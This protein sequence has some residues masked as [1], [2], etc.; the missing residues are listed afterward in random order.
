MPDPDTGGSFHRFLKRGVVLALQKVL[1]GGAPLLAVLLAGVAG[2]ATQVAGISYKLSLGLILTT[3]S[4]LGVS[5]ILLRDLA[6]ASDGRQLP[7]EGVVAL[8]GLLAGFLWVLVLSGPWRAHPLLVDPPALLVVIAIWSVLGVH[9]YSMQAVGQG[10]GRY[11]MLGRTYVASLC[12]LSGFWM[13]AVV[14]GRQADLLIGCGLLAARALEVAVYAVRIQQWKQPRA[15][16][17]ATLRLC[18]SGA[19]VLGQQLSGMAHSRITVL[20]LAGLL[21]RDEFARFSI[22]RSVYSGL[23]LVPAALA[24]GSFPRFVQELRSSPG[25]SALAS[26]GSQTARLIFV[27]STVALAVV[28]ALALVPADWLPLGNV[29]MKALFI[30]MVLA[31]VVTVGTTQ[32]AFLFLALDEEVLLLKWSVFTAAMAIIAV[33]SLATAWGFRGAIASIPTIDLLAIL[34]FAW[35]I[36][37]ILRRGRRGR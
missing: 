12:V 31:S 4:D 35:P 13:A 24:H 7:V 1:N 27:H 20:L 11:R 37:I 33:W 10:L 34:L 3:A 23:S 29:G 17:R 5:R 16:P 14:V 28:L 6:K 25:R 26:L 22:A 21:T 19:L 18:R 9:S 30:T 32:I 8:R 36:R 2:N 15:D